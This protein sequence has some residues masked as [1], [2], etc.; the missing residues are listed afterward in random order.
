MG[1]KRLYP[2]GCSY[3]FL[4]RHALN[5]SRMRKPRQIF[6]TP[7]V[8]TAI[9]PTAPDT[10]ATQ[11]QPSSTPQS[12]AAAT[13]QQQ[14]TLPAQAPSNCTDSASF[15]ADVSIPDNSNV[16][17]GA[18]F[19]K[20]WRIRNTGTCSWNDVY[21]MVFVN[22]DQMNSIASI[23][24]KANRS[25]DTLDLSVDLVAPS[26]DGAYTG[27]YE[28]HNA[29]RSTLSDR[30]HPP[31]MGQDTCRFQCGAKSGPGRDKRKS[32]AGRGC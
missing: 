16:N 11:P 1:S 26:A 32:E 20:T 13:P 3:Y 27:N 9:P 10:P 29:G 30:W 22:G 8:S 21:S 24:F 2:P 6:K 17:A 31:Y 23:P 14:A 4:Q 25:G 5:Q 7:V 19:V 18:A 12:Q 15:V 28:L